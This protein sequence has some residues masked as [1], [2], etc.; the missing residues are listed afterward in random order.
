MRGARRADHVIA[1]LDDRTGDA[2][3]PPRVAQELPLIQPAAMD[4]IMVLDAR[5]GEREVRILESRGDAG[6]GQQRD[7]PPLP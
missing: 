7:R 5:K 4:E 6:I 2:A 3:Q 1:S